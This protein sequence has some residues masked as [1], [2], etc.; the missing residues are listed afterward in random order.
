MS[1]EARMRAEYN[2][3]KDR[4]RELEKEN[5]QLDEII[6]RLKAARDAVAESQAYYNKQ[7][8]A[9]RIT[10]N[11]KYQWRGEQYKSGMNAFDTLMSLDNS[12][13]KDI[14]RP[15]D[16]LEMEIAAAQ[17]KKLDNLGLI[18]RLAGQINSLYHQIKTQFN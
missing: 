12:A 3:K 14:D 2:R 13:V 11:A 15:L 1:E 17:N 9:T 5:D 18:G 8:D 10:A 4:K 6:T 7:K 16:T